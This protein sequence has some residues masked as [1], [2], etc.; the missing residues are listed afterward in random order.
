MSIIS[1]SPVKYVT[2]LASV[3]CDL[4]EDL[5]ELEIVEDFPLDIEY[6]D[7]RTQLINTVNSKRIVVQDSTKI[8][9][10]R[11][12]NKLNPIQSI[13]F[14]KI[15][16]PKNKDIMLYTKPT[17]LIYI[18]AYCIYCKMVGPIAHNEKC[19]RPR[20]TSLKLTLRGI[21][22][23][24]PKY[25]HIESIEDIEEGLE[26]ND[27]MQF[28]YTDNKDI[29]TDKINISIKEDIIKFFDDLIAGNDI[30]TSILPNY[31]GEALSFD[32]ETDVSISVV[33]ANPQKDQRGYVAGFVM[34]KRINEDGV[35][36]NIRIQM[37]PNKECSIIMLS[38][39]YS[40]KNLYL[41]VINRIN[42]N[43][44][45]DRVKISYRKLTIKS[46]LG[47]TIMF[48]DKTKSLNSSKI[49]NHLW[50]DDYNDVRLSSSSIYNRSATPDHYSYI[51]LDTTSSNFYRY[52][53]KGN[54]VTHKDRVCIELIESCKT[55][56][57]GIKSGPNKI[58][59]HV[60]SQGHIQ[61]TFTYCN[62]SDKDTISLDQ[63]WTMETQFNNIEHIMNTVSKQ[64][65]DFLI[66]LDDREGII[67]HTPICDPKQSKLLDTV[68]GAIAYAKKR[69]FEVQTKVQIFD[70]ITMS[71][72]DE[73]HEII[74]VLDSKT[75]N[76]LYSVKM[77]SGKIVTLCHNKLRNDERG[78]DRG[79]DQVCR[80]TKDNA[81]KQPVPY[82]FE[83]PIIQHGY[84]KM[85]KPFGIIGKDNR[86]YP[87]PT[88]IKADDL[89]WL[90]NFVITGI[91]HLERSKYM[92]SYM[93]S[94]IPKT[95]YEKRLDP[96]CG[97]FKPGTTAIGSIILVDKLYKIN[98]EIYED[99]DEDEYMEVEI[100]SKLKPNGSKYEEPKVVIYTVLKLNNKREYTTF[101]VHFHPK[102]LESR[103]FLG[104]TELA[105]INQIKTYVKTSVKQLLIDCLD[106]FNLVGRQGKHVYSNHLKLVYSEPEK[107]RYDLYEFIIPY[108]MNMLTHTVIEVK[109]DGIYINYIKRIDLTFEDKLLQNI[110]LQCLGYNNTFYVIDT[111]GGDTDA[112]RIGTSKKKLDEYDLIN[113]INELIGVE[114]VFN[115][116]EHLYENDRCTKVYID[117]SSE[118]QRYIVPKGI[119]KRNIVLQVFSVSGYHA[120]LGITEDE[121][122]YGTIFNKTIVNVGDY[123][124]V[125]LNILPNGVLY[126]TK[127]TLNPVKVTEAEFLGIE[128]TRELFEFIMRRS[129]VE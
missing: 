76:K 124:E 50:P 24:I 2:F 74:D 94:K 85:V 46:V 3:D 26:L 119:C 35:G 114:L 18:G 128:K 70:Y 45:S 110:K 71:W 48:S 77:N 95:L 111:I 109:S 67:I 38:N 89:I 82:S 56:N 36:V 21:I 40:E 59:I 5:T 63:S 73:S 10:T 90:H 83:Q 13:G 4:A 23:F 61:L 39:P 97:V 86:Y 88:D 122:Y 33:I 117:H 87:C 42:N 115:H 106:R 78:G 72:S 6:N 126:E 112:F 120:K 121:P 16:Y 79:T 107:R 34:I 32:T 68:G 129:I 105:E 104:L 60:F 84:D 15:S 25:N 1:H 101:G 30:Q 64:F 17:E 127:P 31:D 91:T 125:K 54:Y 100:I 52:E 9:S 47:E 8:L 80:L 27:L 28:K 75:E 41:D 37:K 58:H 20:K 49:M 93:Q 96:L 65:V 53:I 7:N 55:V 44:S 69:S 81:Q 98:D 118:K 12:K 99:E 103:D 22:Q 62:Q 102:Y 29:D 14:V 57:D 11:S 108:S 92:I 51:Y 113:T 19:P 66:K 43:Y 116:S 123:V